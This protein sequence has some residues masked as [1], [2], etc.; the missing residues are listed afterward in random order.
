MKLKV[1][2]YAMIGAFVSALLAT[3]VGSASLFLGH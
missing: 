1:V 3:L 2:S